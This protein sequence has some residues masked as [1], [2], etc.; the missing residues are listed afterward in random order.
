MGAG[1]VSGFSPEVFDGAG[2]IED[3]RAILEQVESNDEQRWVVFVD[4]ADR[5]DTAGPLEDL[6]RSAPVHVT[7]IAAVRS[8]A[9]RAG[10]GH[11]TRQV[12]TSGVGLI[13]QPDNSVDGEIL[14]VRLPRSE[15]LEQRPGRGYL[16]Q[17]GTAVDIQLA[18]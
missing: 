5:I 18:Y 11:W 15:R 12:R 9:A 14:S 3:L 16:V 8:S 1:D 6:A 17:S 10:F 13:L 7:L 2:T 4:D